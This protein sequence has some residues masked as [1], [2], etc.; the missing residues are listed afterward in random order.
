MRIE[1]D[2][3]HYTD[4]A[5]AIR[6]MN[7][8]ENAYYP[9]EMAP[10]ILAIP[11][12]TYDVYAP[13]IY[14]LEEREVGVWTDG[15]PLYQKTVPFNFA[16][17]VSNWTLF[18]DSISYDSLAGAVAKLIANNGDQIISYQDRES[19]PRFCVKT[20]HKLYYYTTVASTGYVTI[21]YTKTT[22]VPGSGTWGTDG[23]PMVHYDGTER[24]I[25]TWFGKTLYQKTYDLGSDVSI[26]YTGWTEINANYP[27]NCNLIIQV[28]CTTSGGTYAAGILLGKK[29]NGKFEMQTTRNGNH[30]SLRYFTIKYTKTT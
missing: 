18:D 27:T 29:S 19:T 15:K 25:G 24:I 9:E 30:Q 10:A 12:E 17:G 13:I 11:Q 6:D 26:D 14:S 16:A 8:T 5:E 2:S 22:D 21:Q 20:D 7:G 3:Q 23:V 4:I 1:T 28:D